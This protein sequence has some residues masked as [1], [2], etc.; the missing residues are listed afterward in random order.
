MVDKTI[1]LAFEHTPLD[2]ERKMFG[3]T[4]LL[5]HPCLSLWPVPVFSEIASSVGCCL[6][7]ILQESS[8]IFSAPTPHTLYIKLL[9]PAQP[10]LTHCT[11]CTFLYAQC[12]YSLL[13]PTWVTHMPP[14][15]FYILPQF[16]QQRTLKSLWS[17]EFFIGM[18]RIFTLVF[19]VASGLHPR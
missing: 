4:V 9:L 17:L 13:D 5:G 12:S 6:Q 15:V 18:R 19:R 10:W 16:L 2:K 7:Y 3:G 14:T 1:R 11:S 8:R